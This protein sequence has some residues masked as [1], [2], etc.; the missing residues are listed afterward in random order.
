[1]LVSN[2]MS[3]GHTSTASSQFPP[4]PLDRLPFP[5]SPGRSAFSSRFLSSPPSLPSS[6][7]AMALVAFALIGGLVL[8]SAL[9][10]FAFLRAVK[11][12][13]REAALHAPLLDRF[14]SLSVHLAVVTP[15][16]S[17]RVR[18]LTSVRLVGQL[19]LLLSSKATPWSATRGDSPI[20]AT[21]PAA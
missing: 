7:L 2:T 8:A 9:C 13:Q 19:L 10:V 4:S 14:V 20:Q 16:R 17:R 18:V 21:P 3:E 15:C 1:M 11:R 6:P 5:I 12:H